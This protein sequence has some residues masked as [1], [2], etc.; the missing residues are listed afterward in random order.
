MTKR[1]VLSVAFAVLG[2]YFVGSLTRT[3]QALAG[4]FIHLLQYGGDASDIFD[5]LLPMAAYL[6]PLT[7]VASLLIVYGDRL[8][9]RLVRE[10]ATLHVRLAAGW[11]ES[12]LRIAFALLGLFL[13]AD[14]AAMIARFAMFRLFIPTTDLGGRMPREEWP[15]VIGFAA[16]GV[17]GVYLLVG[18]PGLR[19]FI[20]RR[21]Q[22][23]VVRAGP[24]D[25]A[26]PIKV[27]D[28]EPPPEDKHDAGHW[29]DT[30]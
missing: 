28:A 6:V 21:M 8:A 10:D 14:A 7:V 23:P 29:P 9:R 30:Q 22:R 26:R 1:S 20:L 24:L 4:A 16:K 12:A 3:F 27:L 15:Y 11:E 25:Q 5:T 18:A 13:L 19:Q 2:V 17:F